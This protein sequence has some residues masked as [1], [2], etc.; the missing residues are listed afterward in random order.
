MDA[1]T[2]DYSGLNSRLR[3]YSAVTG[4]PPAEVVREQ[5]MKPLVRVALD[6]TPPGSQTNSGKSAQRAGE[7]AIVRDVGRMGFVPVEI[8]GQ[9]KL[10]HVFGHPLASPIYVPTKENPAFA[11]PAAFRKARLLSKHGGNVTRGR[12]QA[13]YVARRKL[14]PLIKQWQ[15]E[16]GRL[17][18]GWANAAKE[19]G[20]AVPAWI[21]RWAHLGRGTQV[22]ASGSGSKLSLEVVNHFPAGAEDIAADVDRRLP[23]FISYVERSLARQLE[24]F[25]SGA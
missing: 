3:E 8:K 16:V 6:L 24:A 14:T 22:I 11:D 23:Y 19:L 15:G 5:G 9:R 1:V 4:K 2:F 25:Y 12:A 20:V 10:T 21:A 18:S 13:F 7:A 17:A